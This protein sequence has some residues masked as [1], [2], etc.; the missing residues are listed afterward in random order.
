MRLFGTVLETCIGFSF[1]L[2]EVVF[3]GHVKSDI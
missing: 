3:E 2:V 1:D